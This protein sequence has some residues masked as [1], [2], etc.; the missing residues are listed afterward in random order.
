MGIV[1]A[2]AIARH[3]AADHLRLSADAKRCGRGRELGL[4]RSISRGKTPLPA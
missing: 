4:L 2:R 3:W 1:V